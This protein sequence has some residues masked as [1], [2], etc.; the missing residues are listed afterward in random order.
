[1]GAGINAD[2][3]D[4]PIRLGR[5]WC[6]GMGMERDWR[7][8][9]VGL[10]WWGLGAGSTC[11]RANRTNRTV[12]PSSSLGI[13]GALVHGHATGALGRMESGTGAGGGLREHCGPAGGA[14][15]GDDQMIVRDG[16]SRR[17]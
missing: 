9:V 16:A 4:T 6:V 13:Q 1:M 3:W 14:G 8:G 12:L 15:C 5:L 11:G 2:V 10:E 17:V 7:V